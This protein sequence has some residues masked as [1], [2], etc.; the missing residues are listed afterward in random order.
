M[1]PAMHIAKVHCTASQR[2]RHPPLEKKQLLSP[3]FF[4]SNFDTSSSARAR[5]TKKIE[6]VTYRSSSAGEAVKRSV[7]KD[8]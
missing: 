4:L 3:G 8:M 5:T 1:R 6:L 2:R 7:K